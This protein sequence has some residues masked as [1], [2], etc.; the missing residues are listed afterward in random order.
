MKKIL[1]W[2]SIAMVLSLAL[3]GWGEEQKSFEAMMAEAERLWYQDDYPAS[4]RVLDQA[5]RLY[6]KQT[7]PYWRKARNLFDQVEI[8]PRDRKPPKEEL[9][10]TYREVEALGQK[11]MELDPQD[12]N[13]TLW[14]GI[15]MGRRG[16]TQGVLNS[17]GEI[18]DLEAMIL[19]TLELKPTY[20]AEQGKAD[21]MADAYAVLGQF[22][23]VL[24]DWRILSLLFGARGDLEKSVA[25]NR[26]AVELEP[27]RIEHVKELG[28]SLICLG[29]K[30]DQPEKVEEGKKILRGIAGL[31]VIKP[32]DKI[33]QEHAG[34]LLQ[35]PSLACGYSRDAQQE[36]SREAFEKSSNQK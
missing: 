9:L 3:A 23:R 1:A 26:R 36:Q 10:K 24:P 6:P 27:Q 14:K 18:E 31:P 30:R 29:Q 17:L 13:C 25:M 20:R 11:C 34:M 2:V 12:G 21:A 8:I 5:I 28:L 4:N 15:G 35:D 33:D 19:K 22:Y 16:S 32:S 7:E